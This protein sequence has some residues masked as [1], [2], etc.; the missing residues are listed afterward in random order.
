LSLQFSSVQP[1][2]LPLSNVTMHELK[3]VSIGGHH[4][5][6]LLVESL[7]IP[8]LES[9]VLDIEAREPVD[10]LITNLLTRSGAPPLSHLALAYGATPYYYAHMGAVSSWGFLSDLH[11]LESLQVGFTPFEPLLTA[12]G[13]PDE[14]QTTWLCPNLKSISM[15]N[16]HSHNEGVG[17]LVQMVDARNP[18]PSVSAISV[19]GVTPTKLKQLELYDCANLGYDVVEWLQ[20][21]VEDVSFTEPTHERSLFMRGGM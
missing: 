7:K 10:D 18:G 17:K 3:E 8:L 1:P 2:V 21:R 19:N 11:N 13:A 6:T 5:M 15:R 9:L 14:D 20:G 16:C 4:L 12:L